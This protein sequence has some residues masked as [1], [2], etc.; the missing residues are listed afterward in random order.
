MGKKREPLTAE[1]QAPHME[2]ERIVG[3]FEGRD[4]GVP[5]NI[6][7]EY[8]YHVNRAA[9]TLPPEY[10]GLG[11]ADICRA[12]GASWRC[13]SGYY[14]ESCVRVSYEGVEF[15]YERTGNRAVSVTRTPSGELRRVVAFDQWGLSSQTLEYPVKSVS[16]FKALEYLLESVKVEF[17][18]AAYERLKRAVGNNGIV[19][20][21]FPRTPLQSL[22]LDWVGVP[23]TIRMLRLERERVEGL[24]EVIHEHNC[25]FYEAL[26]RSPIRVL[27][28]GENIDVRITSPKLFERYCLPVYQEVA[29]YLH[30]FG[31]FVHAHVDGYARQLLPLL[32][33]SGLDGVEALTPKPAGDFTLEEMKAAL[34]EEMVVLDGI[35]YLLFLLHASPEALDEFVVKIVELFDGRLILGISDELPPPADVS[36]VKR[37]SQ[38]LEK[39]E[40]RR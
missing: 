36:K 28:L 20:C 19:S 26:A 8:W 1:P 25:K 32:R 21:F 33:S 9:G 7:H 37:V 13:Y 29:D 17:D 15:A 39:L 3:V 23:N 4:V 35:P 34:G 24:M 16:D 38:T 30:G 5:F 31:K 12:W 14:V 2:E 6:R 18:Y 22:F 10:T 27:N 40:G 11:L